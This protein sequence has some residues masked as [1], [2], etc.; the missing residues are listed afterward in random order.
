MLPVEYSHWIFGRSWCYSCTLLGSTVVTCSAAVL[1]F[2]GRVTHIFYVD[3]DSDFEA[4]FSPF[5]GRMEKCA[6]SML[7]FESLHVPFALEVWTIFLPGGA[8]FALSV[9]FRTHPQGIESPRVANS[10][11]RL[12]DI[13]I[14]T[15]DATDTTTTTT[16]L[17][18]PGKR[19]IPSF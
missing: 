19:Q 1:A 12:V 17:L 6:Q 11:Q 7:Q 13:D 9:H 5:S 15:E 2:F 10:S 14:L 3:V 16:K 8:F 18:V 4:F